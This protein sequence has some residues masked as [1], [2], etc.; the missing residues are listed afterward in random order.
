MS[1]QNEQDKKPES[2][3]ED[4]FNLT[5]LTRKEF[6]DKIDVHPQ[7]VGKWVSGKSE[8]NFLNIKVMRVV[9]RTEVSIVDYAFKH[10]IHAK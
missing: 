7:T 8:P 4:L 10:G 1:N 5:G 2:W 9:F 6:A 3:V